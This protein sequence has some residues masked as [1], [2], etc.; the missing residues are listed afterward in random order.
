MAERLR[1][2]GPGEWN[3]CFVVV[4]SVSSFAH[5]LPPFRTLFPPLSTLQSVVAITLPYVAEPDEIPGGL[6]TAAYSLF[7]F[8]ATAGVL[9]C[10]AVGGIYYFRKRERDILVEVC[11]C[12]C[13]QEILVLAF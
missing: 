10:F 5:L 12:V 11:V 8:L 6:S 13:G 1:E 4:W 9:L 2:Q 3:A 7:V